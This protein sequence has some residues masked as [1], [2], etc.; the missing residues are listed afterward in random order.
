MENSDVACRK[1][2]RAF[3]TSTYA[4]VALSVHLIHMT[5]LPL[6][7]PRTARPSCRGR[8]FAPGSQGGSGLPPDETVGR[9][10]HSGNA[11]ENTLQARGKKRH[12]V[13]LRNLMIGKRV[14]TA[15]ADWNDRKT[16]IGKRVL[17]APAGRCQWA[18][19]C[20]QPL[21]NSALMEEQQQQ[22]SRYCLVA[23]RTTG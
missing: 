23:L 7:L 5:N 22:S 18:Q 9:P 4:A 11:L 12:V 3:P 21:G 8:K 19:H 17:T 6:L 15:P 14:L 13:S 16:M 2:R 20:L 10:V 1:N